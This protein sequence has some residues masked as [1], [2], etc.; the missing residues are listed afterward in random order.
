[1]KTKFFLILLIVTQ[2]TSGCRKQTS[3]TPEKHNPYKQAFESL[4]QTPSYHDSLYNLQISTLNTDPD[5]YYHVSGKL[6]YLGMQVWQIDSIYSIEAVGLDSLIFINMS[7]SPI[8]K[9]S[10]II[11]YSKPIFYQGL[12]I[13]N[14]VRPKNFPFIS[15]IRLDGDLIY[16]LYA[17]YNTFRNHQEGRYGSYNLKTQE[18]KTD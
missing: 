4:P 3:E 14:K 5:A 13:T 18:L 12:N 1:M 16:L 8:Y 17:D 7:F 2:V 15:E 9:N 11:D 10:A 6:F